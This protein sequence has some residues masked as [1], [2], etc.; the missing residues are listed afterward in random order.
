SSGAISVG[1]PTKENTG[2][3]SLQTATSKPVAESRQFS[4]VTAAIYGNIEVTKGIAPFIPSTKLSNI[5]TFF[6][7]AYKNESKKIVGIS[8]AKA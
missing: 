7:A 6:F 1:I 3:S 4:I 2:D 5:F 8:K